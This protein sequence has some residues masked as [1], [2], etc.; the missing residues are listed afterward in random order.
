MEQD[1][2]V[3]K[4][5]GVLVGATGWIPGR[6]LARPAIDYGVGE[7]AGVV[8]GAHNAYSAATQS[9]EAVLSVWGDAWGSLE[10]R[11]QNLP[12]LAPGELTTAA[13]KGVTATDAKLGEHT[14][15]LKEHFWLKY[16]AM[17]KQVS[18]FKPEVFR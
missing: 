5:S 18:S 3:R 8:Q 12:D 2:T 11:V 15:V 9:D 4:I 10:S 13:D 6:G 17:H 16:S 1:A 7:A 14:G